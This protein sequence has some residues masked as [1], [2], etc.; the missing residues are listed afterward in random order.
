M[1]SKATEKY[2]EHMKRLNTELAAAQESERSAPSSAAQTPSRRP[3]SFGRTLAEV[4]ND[5]QTV[6]ET[7]A[8]LL[9]AYNQQRR[10]FVRR[11]LSTTNIDEQWT[12]VQRKIGAQRRALAKERDTISEQSTQAAQQMLD[13]PTLRQYRH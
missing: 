6:A 12:H 11:R 2:D 1:I 3:E 8:T 4:A 9:V 7:H 10:D 5:E 13:T